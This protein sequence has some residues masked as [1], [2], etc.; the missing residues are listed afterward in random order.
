VNAYKPEVVLWMAKLAEEADKFREVF[1]EPVYIVLSGRFKDLRHPDLDNL[2]KVVCDGLK[3]GLGID[4]KHFRV[5]AGDIVIDWIEPP[6]LLLELSQ[7]P[8]PVANRNI[9]GGCII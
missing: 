1:N 7:E 2:F 4:D 9:D 3:V 5:S 6:V 8:I